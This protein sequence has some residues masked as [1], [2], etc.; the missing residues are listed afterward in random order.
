LLPP[1]HIRWLIS[2]PEHILSHEKANEDIHALPFLAPAFDN[3]AH[4]ELIKAISHDLTRNIA[5]TDEALRDELEHTASEMLGHASDSSWR[6]VNI[7]EALDTIIFGVCLRIFFGPSLCRDAKYIYL[8]KTWTR[9]TGGMMIA[10]SQLI[11][12]PLKPVVGILAGLPIYYYWLRIIVFLYPTYKQRIRCLQTARESAP[13]DM[14]TW[15]VDLALKSN[16]GKNPGISALIVRLTLVV[17]A[18]PI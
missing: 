3:S 14:V 10:V 2:Q 6:E 16:P 9:V 11:P 7:A 1:E 17:S 18:Q 5:S 13:E 15:M 4:L 12:W 8:V